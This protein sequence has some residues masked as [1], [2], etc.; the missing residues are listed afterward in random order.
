MTDFDQ[1]LKQSLATQAARVPQSS[2]LGRGAVVRGRSIRRRRRVVGGVAFAAVVAIAVPVGLEV[3]DSVSRN[4][5]QVAPA[6]TGPTTPT[7]ITGPRQV[8]LDL[9]ALPLADEPPQI[10]YVEGQTVVVGDE[11][12]NVDATDDLKAVAAFDGGA[13]AY[14][15]RNGAAELVRV[16]P[17]GSEV[18]G[19]AAGTPI[20]S[21][22]LRWNAYALGDVDKFGNVL[23]GITLTLFDSQDGSTSEI[24]LPAANNVDI[25][26]LVDG[27]V[28][29]RPQSSDGTELPLQSWAAGEAAPTVVSGSFAATA[30]SPNGDLV[31]DLTK[32]TDFG[33][34]TCSDVVDL[35]SGADVWATCKN[36]VLG[37]SPDGSFAWA[38]PE[39]ADGYAPVE[40]AI[41]DAR[42]GEV[43]RELQGPGD[44]DHP[45][46]FMNA[47]FEDE[48]HLLIRAEQDGQTAL[49]RCT[50]PTGECE[51][52]LP[53]VD[54]TS[55][56]TGSPYLLSN[57]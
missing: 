49:V 17:E 22:D 43:I 16:T 45:V 52:A 42:T 21:A 37:F 38:G 55:D 44:I 32:V 48:D 41:L 24:N 46:F 4:D 7:E 2:D 36:Q 3:G 13:H 39:Y 9:T 26:A 31:A 18:L 51:S 57:F 29:L 5:G 34:Q 40:I 14:V 20:A 27:T 23:R 1:D 30:V 53:P 35:V 8:Q 47:S 33:T 6:T 56:T 54:G 19:A 50:V 11:R 12:Y 25:Y 15:S 10:P 28:Y